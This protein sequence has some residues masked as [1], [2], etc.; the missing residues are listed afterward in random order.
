MG[1]STRSPAPAQPASV[2]FA[3]VSC[4]NVCEGAQNAYRRMIYEDQRTEPDEQLAFVLH[5]GDFISKSLTILRTGRVALGALHPNAGS[6]GCL[7]G[8]ARS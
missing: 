3:F 8:R 6:M 5:L 1:R 4:Q 7:H 2:R